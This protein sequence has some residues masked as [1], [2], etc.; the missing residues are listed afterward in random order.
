MK[1]ILILGEMHPCNEKHLNDSVCRYMK[2]VEAE[3]IRRYNPEKIF[4]EEWKLRADLEKLTGEK[5]VKFKAGEN[6]E[7]DLLTQ[8][9]DTISKNFRT[10]AII[11][12]FR[13]KSAQSHFKKMKF[14]ADYILL[15]SLT[16]EIY[17]KIF[18]EE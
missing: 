17:E 16:E 6:Y 10:L 18:S 3:I 7:N 15:A 14:S 1:N 5:L 4:I 13:L 9:L 8:L 12:A 11:G 2:N